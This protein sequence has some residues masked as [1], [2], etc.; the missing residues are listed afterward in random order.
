MGIEVSRQILALDYPEVTR[1]CWQVLALLKGCD[2]AIRSGGLTFISHIPRCLIG[3]LG[4]RFL[5]QLSFM[6]M[7]GASVF[8]YLPEHDGEYRRRFRRSIHRRRGPNFCWSNSQAR[9][10]VVSIL[11]SRRIS[12][13]FLPILLKAQSTSSSVAYLRSLRI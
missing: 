1:K 3:R 10:S 5:A 12:P 2:L 6:L 4:R 13:S 11:F 9:S 8:S 7:P